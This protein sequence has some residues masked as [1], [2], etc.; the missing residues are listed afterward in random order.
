MSDKKSSDIERLKHKLAQADAVAAQKSNFLATMSHEIRTPMQAVYGYLE[1]IE[2]EEPGEKILHMARTARQAASGLLEILDDILDFAKMDAGQMPLDDFEVPIRT[3]VRGLNEALAVK[4]Q[5][6]TVELKDDIAEE[7]P[8]VIEGDPK[9]LRQVLMNLCGNAIK[10]TQEGSVTIRVTTDTQHIKP[11][12][13]KTALRF[14][15]IDTGM[16]MSQDV[17]DR[18]FR[19]FTQADN[20]TSRR[21]GGTGLGLSIAKKLIDLMEGKIGVISEQGRGSIFWFEIAAVAV[22]TD[23]KQIAGNL[24]N[25]DGLSILSVEDH[26]QGA[27]EIKRT[28]ESMGAHVDLCVSYAEAVQAAIQRPFDVALVDQGL[29]DGNGVDLI[30]E[31]QDLRPFMGV[32]MYTVRDDAGLQH[33][34][35]SLGAAYVTKPASRLGLGEAVQTAAGKALRRDDLP[36]QKLLIA[37]DTP[38]VQDVLKQ[39]LAQLGCDA[40]MAENG[41]EAWAMVQQEEYGL[42]ITDLHMPEMDGY[43]FVQKIRTHKNKGKSHLPVIVMTAD[44]QLNQRQVYTKH[45]FDECLLKPVSLG[46]LRR[47]LMRWGLITEGAIPETVIAEQKEK[48]E[49]APYFDR[50]ALEAQM[51]SINEGIIKLLNSFLEMTAPQI[52]ELQSFVAQ[53]DTQ[54]AI[55]LAHSLKGAAWSAGAKRLGNE[56]AA[57]QSA[58]EN[59]RLKQSDAANLP[60]I[61][62]QTEKE[63]LALQK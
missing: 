6:K 53:N 43:E 49:N 28:L 35:Q 19:P 45:G 9:R 21:F 14:E 37:E 51:G 62:K 41:Q 17:A 50:A 60:D 23:A 32:I 20:S 56:A 1:L 33:T 44:V 55:E 2:Q 57:I 30:R 47:L 31:L 29:P 5:G 59:N 40:V 7:V 63:I 24:P 13:Q 26:P 15:V 27:Q 34:L 48:N 16:G 25:L 38:L 8:F 11:R 22:A 58:G 52:T 54:K 46:Q 39:Q 36:I 3:L 4:V 12:G 10:F 18:L 42:I 61:F